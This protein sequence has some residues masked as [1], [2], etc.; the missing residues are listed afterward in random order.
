MPLSLYAKLRIH[1]E[2]NFF[3]FNFFIFFFIYLPNDQ[4]S[5]EKVDPLAS[6]VSGDM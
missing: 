5:A 3:S 1:I 4:K 6:I 2:F